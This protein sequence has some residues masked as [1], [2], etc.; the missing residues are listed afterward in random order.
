MSL[1]GNLNFKLPFGK[2]TTTVLHQE[3][4]N[5][6]RFYDKTPILN[7][8]HININNQFVKESF[9]GSY[10]NEKITVDVSAAFAWGNYTNKTLIDYYPDENNGF[11]IKPS[12]GYNGIDLQ[13]QISY[14]PSTKFDFMVGVDQTNDN[15]KLLSYVKINNATQ[16]SL[17]RVYTV[18]E[19][20]FSNFGTYAQGILKFSEKGTFTGGVRFDKHNIY[21]NK[22]NYRLGLVYSFSESL[23]FKLL[24]G[25]SFRAPVP[26][27]LFSP[28]PPYDYTDGSIGNREL[29]PETAQT[30]ES[31]I[32]FLPL[33]NISFQL[34]GFYNL[35]NSV[36]VI[37]QKGGVSRP[38]NQNNITSFGSEFEANFKLK[39]FVFEFNLSWQKSTFFNIDKEKE[40]VKL[41]PDIMTNENINYSLKYVNINIQ[42]YFVNSYVASQNNINNNIVFGKITPYKIN[43]YLLFDITAISKNFYIFGNKEKLNLIAQR[44]IKQNEIVFSVTVKNLLNV[45]YSY[46]G[47]YNYDIPGF[48]R[49]LWFNISLYL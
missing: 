11:A 39:N 20:K 3:L 27:Q 13:A 32:N 34:T 48:R 12:L 4:D 42:S 29:I 49:S 25:T 24:Y 9:N 38:V 30:I 31:S 8:T 16:I 28:D 7:D 43:K 14:T 36:I 21:G 5:A 47:F 46:P 10:L 19:D 23:Y 22:F 45:K 2:L 17:D 37:E 44:M 6:G 18:G 26:I 1:Y 41:F 40:D 15:H 35:L 33:K